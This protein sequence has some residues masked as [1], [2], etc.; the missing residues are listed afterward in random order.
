MSQSSQE[1][2]GDRHDG[3]TRRQSDDPVGFWNPA[4]KETR[5]D[6]AKH[7]I[8]TTFILCAFILAVL[9]IYWGVE[10]RVEENLSSLVVWV[11]DFDGQEAP[12]NTSG[13]TPLVGPRIVR[14][15]EA[16]IAPKG[17][18]G[19]GSLPPSHFHNNPLEVRQ[20]I[21]DYKA[22]AAIIINANATAL[23]QEAV[24]MGNSSYDP[25]GAMQVI[26]VQ[27]RDQ[28]TIGNYM[29]P[30]LQAFQTQVTSSF[31][32]MWAG[33]VLSEASTNDT[34][35]ANIRTSPQAISPAI[36]F[37][38][39]NLRPFSPAVITPT[40]TVGL[41][42]LIIMAF[43]SFG[44]FMPIHMKFKSPVHRTLKFY[45][46]IIWRWC[47]TIMAYFFISLS[48]S[49]VSLSF[50]I[51]F[52]K[53]ATSEVMVGQPANAYHY[54]SFP[55][56]WT[57]NFVGMMA[58]GLASENMAMILGQPCMAFWLIFWVIT[59]VSTSFY[60]ITLAPSFYNWGYA[61]PLHNVV[62]ATRS[63]VFDLHSEIGLNFGVLSAWAAINTAFFPF[64]CY[65]MRWKT[66][67][68][69]KKGQ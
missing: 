9:S 37:S 34:I 32:K 67:R 43:F 47:S 19:W 31:G 63:I 23:L 57:V 61:W 54:G 22:W 51:S 58:L 50:Q 48:Y 13:V 42:Y 24:R 6:V 14:A 29:I 2:K 45:Q 60:A 39:F 68:A 40:V 36:G 12:Y 44:F 20:R 41:I 66:R 17:S 26:Y 18:L 25:M 53:P 49:L 65:F 56:Y 27:A 46:L 59:N 64:C 3:E 8:F 1:E 35:L 55:V 52:S 33:M 15:A 69:E 16:L 5:T 38:T 62:E 10:F 11:V 21:Y 4:L 28:E 7:W 30:Q